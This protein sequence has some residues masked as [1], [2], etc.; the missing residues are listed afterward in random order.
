MRH[1]TQLQAESSS[2]TSRKEFWSHLWRFE[3]PNAGKNYLWRACHEILSTK[4]SLFRRKIT[5]DALCHICTLEEETCSAAEEKAKSILSNLSL[6]L[7]QLKTEA[8]T[9]EKEK[10]FFTAETATIKAEILKTD[11]K[12]VV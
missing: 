4:A 6:T 7:E 2:T 9:A 5:K 10:E 3:I 1:T 11:R 12:S 8:G